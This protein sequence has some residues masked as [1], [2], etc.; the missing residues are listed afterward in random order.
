M[1][2]AAFAGSQ[3]KL[4]QS[5]RNGGAIIFVQFTYDCDFDR[6]SATKCK[7]TITTTRLDDFTESEDGPQRG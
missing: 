3:E 7:P 6:V 1:V 5:I 2:T 4:A